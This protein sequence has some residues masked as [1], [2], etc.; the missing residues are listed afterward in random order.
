MA[1]FPAW[2]AT[3][4]D[5]I[6]QLERLHRE[7]IIRPDLEQL[8]GI[9]RRH[10]GVLMHRFGARSIGHTLILDRR[11]LIRQFKALHRGR[12]FGNKLEVRREE[13]LETLRRARVDHFPAPVSV[14]GSGR[15]P[16]GRP[17]ELPK[18][19][20]CSPGLIEV[21]FTD[22]QEAVQRLYELAQSLVNDFETFEALTKTNVH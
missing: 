9:S 20:T 15:R 19:V 2:L 8:F 18:G 14:R 16:G 6:G 4:P 22:A 1:R 5:A 13:L 10:A 17:G 11:Q 7:I 21:S 3:L 12:A